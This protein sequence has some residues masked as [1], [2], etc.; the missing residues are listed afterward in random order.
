MEQYAFTR[1][2][3]VE[4]EFVDMGDAAGG[5]MSVR[6]KM[7]GK[8]E[9]DEGSEEEVCDSEDEDETIAR[10]QRAH[11]AQTAAMNPRRKAAARPRPMSHKRKMEA[12][13]SFH[14]F[15]KKLKKD[16]GVA[17]RSIIGND[18]LDLSDNS[19]EDDKTDS[20]GLSDTEFE[21]NPSAVQE[22]EENESYID[23]E[24][25]DFVQGK[26]IE[27]PSEV[28]EEPSTLPPTCESVVQSEEPKTLTI[29]DI[30][31]EGD[32]D[33]TKNVEISEVEGSELCPEP[34][35]EDL[36]SM[37]KQDEGSQ[38]FDM[39]E[40]LN[41]MEGISEKP[42]DVEAEAG[43][44]QTEDKKPDAEEEVCLICSCNFFF[45]I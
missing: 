14:D 32:L 2:R 25:G 34:T 35:A 6:G 13:K 30:I 29:S 5:T 37:A 23:P 11:F 38:D 39:D 20:D 19:S 7:K 3:L 18:I 15:T 27:K 24:T 26:K 41:E 21:V 44:D 22:L 16:T 42:L 1:V 9:D 40:K 43:K 33:L 31:N 36:L 8:L 17:I 12:V 45:S 28:T 4:G 10:I